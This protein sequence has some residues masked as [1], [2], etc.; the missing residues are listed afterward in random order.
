MVL[1]RPTKAKGSR[2][3]SDIGHNMSAKTVPKSAPSTQAWSASDK[4]CLQRTID[5]LHNAFRMR[6]LAFM[7][8]EGTALLCAPPSEVYE[9]L[10]SFLSNVSVIS[11]LVL[12]AIAGVALEPLDPDEYARDKRDAVE[13]FNVVAALTVVIQLCTCLFSTFTLYML[14]STSHNPQAVYRTT[15]H[16]TRWIGLL[17]FM[18]YV[19]AL[20]TLALV[21]IA[22]YLRCGAFGFRVVI[23]GTCLCYVGM[24]IGFDFMCASAFPYNNW[25]W[26]I[27]SA[28]GIPFCSDFSRAAAKKHGGLLVAQAQHGVLS[29]LDENDDY[30]ID[31]AAAQPAAS[32]A[33]AKLASWLQ[34]ALT[35]LSAVQRETLAQQLVAAGLTKSRIIDAVHCPGGFQ[36]LC[37]MLA[38]D[39]F[40]MRPGDRLAL[41]SAASSAHSSSTPASGYSSEDPPVLAAPGEVDEG[42]G[43]WA[44]M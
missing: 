21:V 9:R 38:A 31:D 6:P 8:S 37:G 25:A 18:T 19:P 34:G 11:G 15:L 3:K 12:S 30:V 28:F 29:G 36:S 13:V 39:E 10:M 43:P 35:N 44:C 7:K 20:G 4:A 40:R 33:E 16:M 22:M 14:T 1:L 23:V 2:T 26:S 42:S 17:E 41:A 27:V 5:P 32:E 24:Q